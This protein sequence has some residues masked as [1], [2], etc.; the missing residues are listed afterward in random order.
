MVDYLDRFSADR[1]L[2]EVD[3]MRRI[4]EPPLTANRR[5]LHRPQLPDRPPSRPVPDPPLLALPYASRPG[6]RDEW[7]PT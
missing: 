2:V 1:I 7:H 4:L 3:A 6:Y 5:P